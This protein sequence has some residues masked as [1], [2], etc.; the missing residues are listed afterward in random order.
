MLRVAS[1]PVVA[2]LLL[3]LPFLSG[4]ALPP[5]GLLFQ[6][7]LCRSRGDG[8]AVA[9]PPGCPFLENGS[10]PR[11]GVRLFKSLLASGHLSVR[12][13]RTSCHSKKGDSGGA[14]KDEEGDPLRNLDEARVD[15]WREVRAK[16]VTLEKVSP[17]LS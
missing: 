6:R 1:P 16:M 5:G 14:A 3:F 2:A 12:Q 10:M 8:S 17:Q 9:R 13:R 7:L 4:F 11:G 15:D